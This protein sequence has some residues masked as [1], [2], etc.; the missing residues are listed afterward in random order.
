MGWSFKAMSWLEKIMYILILNI[1]WFLGVILGFGVLGIFPATYSVFKLFNEKELFE[2]QSPLSPIIK[3]FF[4]YYLAYFIRANVVGLLYIGTIY[5]LLIDWRII[6][7][8][9]L[10]KSLFSIP[11]I[12]MSIY[13]FETG[14]F[15]IPISLQGEGTIKQKIKLILTA[16]LLL[17]M[18]SIVNLI[19]LLATV[20]LTNYFTVGVFIIY[21]SLS[22]Y[23]FNISCTSA[24]YKK[25]LLS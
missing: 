16:P 20:L 25:R 19:V 9:E 17:P 10:L 1:L 2:P 7:Y 14:L 24:L 18:A 11:I 13:I 22:I 4:K 21:I 15:L 12:L 23:V 8:S 3:A 6:Q 5:I